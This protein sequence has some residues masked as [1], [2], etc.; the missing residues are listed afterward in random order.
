MR[1]MYRQKSAITKS[2]AIILVAVI[3]IAAA[4]AVGIFTIGLPGRS[5][6]PT[7]E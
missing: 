3:V 7:A 2:T 4:A 6:D 1:G 5:A